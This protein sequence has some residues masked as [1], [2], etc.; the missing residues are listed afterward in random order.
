VVDRDGNEVQRFTERLVQ[1]STG[2]ECWVPTTPVGV[3]LSKK[4]RIEVLEDPS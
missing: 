4:E 3:R 1:L 2:E